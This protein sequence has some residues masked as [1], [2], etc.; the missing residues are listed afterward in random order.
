MRLLAESYRGASLIVFSNMDRFLVPL[1]IV[2]AL[3]LA[4][5]LFS[6]VTVH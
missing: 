3:L 1:L 2:A 5:S 6:Y 4:G